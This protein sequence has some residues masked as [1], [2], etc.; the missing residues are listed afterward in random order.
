MMSNNTNLDTLIL[1]NNGL[2]TVDG[3]SRIFR[4]NCN[5]CYLAV[6]INSLN[7]VD[8]IPLLDNGYDVL[9]SPQA[10]VGNSY[11]LYANL[12]ESAKPFLLM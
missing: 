11:T 1:T 5:N 2:D 6:D 7:F 9:Y 12:G 4:D 10:R 3:V 8:I